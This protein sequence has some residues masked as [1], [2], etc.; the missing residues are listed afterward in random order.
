[1]I[2]KAL[3]IS[4]GISKSCLFNTWEPWQAQVIRPPL[5]VPMLPNSGAWG[6][7]SRHI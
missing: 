6:R 1:L 7:R 5:H 4:T 3:S 2:P